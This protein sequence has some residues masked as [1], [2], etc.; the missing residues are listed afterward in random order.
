MKLIWALLFLGL[1]GVAQA[2][3]ASGLRDGRRH[4]ARGMARYAL[5]DFEGAIR[6]F[7]TAYELTHAPALLFNL[8]QASRLARKHEDALHFYRGY[9]RASPDAAN[10]VDAEKFIDELEPLVHEDQPA[11]SSPEA[12]SST[13]A[14]RRSART[15]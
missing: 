13:W 4:H 1:V 5:L 9:L 14:A 10:R 2:G 12:P 7:R 8:A 15:S 3:S 11:A 6:E